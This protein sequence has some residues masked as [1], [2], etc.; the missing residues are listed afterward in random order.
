MICIEC[1]AE[2]KPADHHPIDACVRHLTVARD[3]YRSALCDIV[4]SASQSEQE[5]PPDHARRVG[6][7]AG[8]DQERRSGR[9]SR[10]RTMKLEDRLRASGATE[11]RIAFGDDAYVTFRFRHDGEPE[12]GWDVVDN[13]RRYPRQAAASL[14]FEDAARFAKGM[15]APTGGEVD[16]G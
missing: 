12:E 15:A 8:A 14:T 2:V 5:G 13:R 11:V 9:E 1:G 6:E 16:R 7:G 10:G 4:A 3:A